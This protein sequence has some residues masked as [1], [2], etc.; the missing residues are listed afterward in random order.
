[1]LPAEPWVWTRNAAAGLYRI[2]RGLD[3]SRKATE[4]PGPESRGPEPGPGPPRLEEPDG[5]EEPHG[6][7]VPRGSESATRAWVG[8]MEAS[9]GNPAATVERSV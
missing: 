2:V 3:V 6:M 9:G 8:V 5:T 4:K 7:E 1:M